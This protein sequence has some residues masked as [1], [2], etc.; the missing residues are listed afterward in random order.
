VVKQLSPKKKAPGSSIGNRARALIVAGMA[1]SSAPIASF[2]F[3]PGAYQ[4]RLDLQA[5]LAE[6]ARQGER[7]I[8]SF[9]EFVTLVDPRFH[10]FKHC[11]VLGDVLQRVAD[12]EINRLM[13][14]MPPR[15]GKSQ[16]TSRLFSAYFL[17]R[18]PERKVGL[19]SYSA[20][21]AYTLSRAAKDY[22]LASGSTLRADAKAVKQWETPT[23]GMFWACGVGG[24]ATGKGWHLGIVDD[25]LKNAEQA[26]SVK[27][28]EKQKEWFQS[29][30]G[31]RE[32]PEGGALVFIQ[33][34][35]NEDDLSGWQLAVEEGASEE[36][37]QRWH[38]VN[39]AAIKEDLSEEDAPKFPDSCTMEPDWRAEGEALCPERY[40]LSKLVV[41]KGQVGSYFWAALYQQRPRPKD[42]LTFKR[43]WIKIRPAFPAGCK[44]VRYWDKARTQDGGD[45]SVGVLMG[46]YDD[47]DTKQSTFYIIDVVR[48]QW[49][50]G[51]RDAVIRQT[52]ETDSE[53]YGSG[54]K[55]W[56]EQ[57][58]AA[59]GKEATTATIRALAGF[60]VSADPVQKD[61]E[62]RAEP[63]S[64]QCQALNV[65]LVRGKWNQIF[66]M[67]LCGFPNGSHD[68]QVDATSGAFNKLAL[69]RRW[70]FS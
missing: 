61:K 45:Y 63:L 10:W 22:Y 35:W 36:E 43:E 3:A 69:G 48:G 38:I 39:F 55:I 53:T 16:Q 20:G 66:L 8:L 60:S 13:I 28:R 54:V 68:D 7:K 34:R 32:E 30:F 70:D 25:S 42:G 2:I 23:G 19:A 57:E 52:A 1:L 44:L 31:T 51:N 6:E 24:E 15:H 21:L 64:V 11:Q 58:P 26:A 62:T 18:F 40:P 41:Y 29:T 4:A 9:R 50:A 59:A 37:K 27:I 14:F 33:T 47:P 46:R 67:E 12:G 17:Y 65:F 56:I 5:R 49:S